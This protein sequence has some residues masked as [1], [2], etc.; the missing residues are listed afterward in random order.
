MATQTGITVAAVNAPYTV[1][2]DLPRPKPGPK[3]ILVKGVATGI[4]PV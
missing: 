3:Q 4:N 2:D 1:V